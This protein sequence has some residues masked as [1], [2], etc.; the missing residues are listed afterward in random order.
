VCE[1]WRVPRSSVYALA[2]VARP[3]PPPAKRGPKTAQSDAEIVG[4]ILESLRG[5][6]LTD[7]QYDV[8]VPR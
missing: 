1:E 2:A 5:P 7:E 3:E 8:Y 4:L 6:T